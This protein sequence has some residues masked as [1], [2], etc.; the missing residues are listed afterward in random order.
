MELWAKLCIAGAQVSKGY[1]NNPEKT[2]ESF[3]PNNFEKIQGYEVLYKTGDIARIMSDGNYQI[4]GRAD[5][6]VKIRGYRVELSE[7]E[8]IISSFENIKELKHFISKSKPMYMVP[9]FILQIPKIPL[10]QNHKLDEKALPE[11]L[12][13][14]KDFAM[15]INIIQNKLY[16]VLG[17]VLGHKNFGI[18]DNIFEVGLNSI[19]ASKFL[20]KCLNINVKLNYKDIFTHQSIEKLSKFVDNKVIVKLEKK[21]NRKDFSKQHNNSK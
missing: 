5:K 3:V 14:K 18:D 9:S 17:E 10:T 19:L 11:P 15:P 1:I 12:S 4:L 8:D 7:I 2:K 20:I 16:D 21:Q 6:Q 13:A